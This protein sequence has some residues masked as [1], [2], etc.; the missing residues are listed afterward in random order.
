MPR[1]TTSERERH[2]DVTV[3][4]QDNA[5]PHSARVTQDFLRDN[6]VTVLEWPPYSPDLSP[7][8]HPWDQ[9]KTAID[10]RQPRPRNRRELVQA[11]QEEWE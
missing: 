9:L 3:F 11:V 6:N 8:E 10:R 2:A 7:I 5:R 1:L 4:Q